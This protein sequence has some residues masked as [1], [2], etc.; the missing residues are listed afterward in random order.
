M[1]IVFLDIDGVLNNGKFL[2]YTAEHASIDPWPNGHIDP[3]AIKHL[4]WLLEQS[5]A[6]VVISSS[7][8]I[9]LK[10][11]QIREVLNKEGFRGRIIGS[12]PNL[13]HLDTAEKPSCRGHEIQYW[14]DNYKREKIEGFVILDDDPDMAH[15]TDTNFVQTD[16]YEG[17]TADKAQEAL[18]ILM[19]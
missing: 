6:S 9:I 3:E 1:Y 5:D 2:T 18:K 13:S 7:W 14:L 12:T 16:W 4:N 15:L 11:V 10:L 17:L 8:R 19:R